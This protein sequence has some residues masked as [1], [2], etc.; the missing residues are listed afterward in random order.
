[1]DKNQLIDSEDLKHVN[2]TRVVYTA[3]NDASAR[4]IQEDTT[5][6]NGTFGA[7]RSATSGLK[8]LSLNR[9]KGS[10]TKNTLGE[11]PASLKPSEQ[12]QVTCTDGEENRAYAEA[13]LEGNMMSMNGS[14]NPHNT[15]WQT[16]CHLPTHQDKTSNDARQK[17]AN[18]RLLITTILCAIFMIL[19]LVGGYVA[20]S[21]SIMT[22][23][24][25]LFS[26]IASFALSLLAVHLSAQK[27]NRRYTFGYQRAEILGAVCSILLIWALTAVVVYLAI[28]RL[29]TMDFEIESGVMMVVSLF[30]VGVNIL[31]GKCNMQLSM[32]LKNIHCNF[33]AFQVLLCMVVCA[34]AIQKQQLMLQPMLSLGNRMEEVISAANRMVT[35]IHIARV[36][37]TNTIMDIHTV[38]HTV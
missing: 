27:S 18:R 33:Y 2:D 22:D 23:A 37:H 12:R 16:H 21:L 25:H 17:S 11:S 31:M 7:L 4:G 32:I 35:I 5:G 3:N 8:L 10:S 38:I 15:D 29:I 36:T 9:A 26:D 30:G 20:N 24:A 6:V 1:M 13:E 19:E 28:Q 34:Q 14:S